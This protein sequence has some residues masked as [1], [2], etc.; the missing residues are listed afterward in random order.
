MIVLFLVIVTPTMHAFWR[1]TGMARMADFVNFTKNLGLLGAVLSLVA[2]PEPWPAS[3]KVPFP[4]VR[5]H[6]HA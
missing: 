2:I 6:V 3:V 1:E 5:K 4:G